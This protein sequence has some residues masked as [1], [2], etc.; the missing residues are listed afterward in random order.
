MFVATYE[1]P[2]NQQINSNISNFGHIG[3]Y[4]K[5]WKDCQ[6]QKLVFCIDKQTAQEI[7]NLYMSFPLRTYK[8]QPHATYIF[9]ENKTQKLAREIIDAIENG[10]KDVQL[11]TIPNKTLWCESA[12]AIVLYDMEIKEI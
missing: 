4:I 10:K 11:L 12:M 6:T 1:L 5:S 7:G 3:Q 8:H 9:G 2:D